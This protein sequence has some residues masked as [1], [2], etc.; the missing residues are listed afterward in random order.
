MNIERQKYLNQLVDARGNGSIKVIS[1]LR[2]CGKS[3]MLKKLFK[4]YLLTDGVDESHIILIDLENWR[5]KDFKNPEYLLDYVDSKIIDT[6]IY[7]ILIDEVQKV[8]DFVEVLATLLLKDNVEIYVTG[9]NSKFLS[10]DIA[11]DFRG[12]SDEIHM[13]PLSF[14]EFLS[15]YDGNENDALLEYMNYGGLP[16]ILLY[17]D[18]YA[19]AN[20]L[21]KIYRTV[22]L[23][24]I[25][26]RHRIDYPDEFEELMKI[27]ASSIGSLTN[28]HKLA[29]SFKSKK[30]VKDL[31][32]KTITL[33][34][35]YLA[36]A[37]LIESAEQYDI[38]GKNY[39][40]SPMKYYF[41]DLGLRNSILSF[42]QIEETHLME[43]LIFNE[44]KIR[45]FLVDIGVVPVR[46]RNAEGIQQRSS[47]EVD[48]VANKGSQR[49]YI[50]S[51]WKMPTEE[52]EEQEL[53]SLRSI[54]DSFKKIIITGENIHLKRDESGI[55]TMNVLQFLKNSNSLDL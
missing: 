29:N 44:L 53:R 46:T 11:T 55:T 17:K 48:F 49:Y 31:S 52:K 35:K 38:K 32:N 50:Q 16:Q 27:I 26:E 33:Y 42:R 54:G 8:D 18:D 40:D 6:E 5:F 37:F 36:D 47:Y 13:Y 41:Q 22:Y 1:G 25:Y 51:A 14:S 15:A 23:K 20:F 21:R 43:N 24:D 34:L 19:K 3:Y 7:Y 39:I 10:S 9:S 12:R 2:R 45:G 30:N 4:S 28:P